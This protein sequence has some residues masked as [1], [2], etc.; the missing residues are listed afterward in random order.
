MMNPIKVLV[1]DDSAFM[2]ALIKDLLSNNKRIQVIGTARNGLDALDKI[3]RLK[4]DVVT[5]DVEMPVMDGIDALK[6][7]MSESPLPVIM[8]S[9]TTTEGAKN[10]IL[11]MQYGAFDFIAKPSGSISLDLYK[12]KD[13]LINRILETKRVNLKQLVQADPI[14]PKPLPIIDDD[15]KQWSIPKTNSYHRG[16]NLF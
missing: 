2:R 15:R 10:T 7:I 16:K 14:G 13:E 8:V 6:K 4:P 1:V 5:L 3:K 9:S 11:A 12:V